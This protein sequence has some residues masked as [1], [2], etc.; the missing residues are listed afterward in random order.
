MQIYDAQSKTFISHPDSDDEEPIVDLDG[1]FIYFLSTVNVDRL[2][3]A[4]RITPL[5]SSIP[6]ND[7]SCELLVVRP[8]RDPTSS[9]DNPQARA[10]FVPKLWAVMK[11]AYADGNH[12]NLRYNGESE[13]SAE[14]VGPLVVEYIRCG[15]W[16]WLPLV[17]LILLLCSGNLIYC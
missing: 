12:I 4:F 6:P 1:P 10:A 3:P 2:E 14:G 13:L 7:V 15:G 5:A 11:G 9:W 17:S 8:L 16:E